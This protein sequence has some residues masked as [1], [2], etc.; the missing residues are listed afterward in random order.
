MGQSRKARQEP[1]VG[2]G[3]KLGWEGWEFWAK[4]GHRQAQVGKAGQGRQGHR[5]PLSGTGWGWVGKSPA[6]VD[7]STWERL[8]L[9]AWGRLSCQPTCSPRRD[10]PSTKKQGRSVTLAEEPDK[11]TNMKAHRPH[12]T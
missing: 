1:E 10:C 3:P 7:E 4:V 8:L 2:T 12:P 5:W 11:A 9:P 6:G